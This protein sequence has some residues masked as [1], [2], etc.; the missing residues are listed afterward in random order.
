M[1]QA[2]STLP[3]RL[4]LVLIIFCHAAPL[5]A[6]TKGQA[7][8]FVSILPQKYFVDHI[9]GQTLAVEVMVAKGA[10]PATYEPKPREMGALARARLYL[11][12]GVPFE[13]AW[14]DKFAGVS[15]DMKIVRTQEGI[16]KIDMAARH[17][18]AHGPGHGP[19]A[20][21]AVKDPHVWTAPGPAKIIAK[22]IYLALSDEFPT[23]KP[24]FTANYNRLISAMDRLDQ[25]LKTAFNQCENRFFMVFHPSWGYF[26]KAYGLHQLPIEIEGKA[27]KPAQLAKVI[28]T[29]RQNRITT[30]FVQPQF[31]V[32]SATVIAKAINGK[33]VSADP[34]AYDWEANL[35][36]QASAFLTQ[37]EHP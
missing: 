3:I 34:L 9:S 27:P 22:N 29:A 12:I 5:S 17:H 6:M 20:D 1:S 25:D 26:A 32:Q 33:V 10:N 24:L 16:V 14:L 36:R 15:P 30:V 31:S 28:Q 37:K 4:A 19:G 7:E 13:S 8:I 35:R 11:A 21:H 23:E 18:E 2:Q